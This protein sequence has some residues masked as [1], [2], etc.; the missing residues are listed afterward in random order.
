M[1]SRDESL[2]VSPDGSA[3]SSHS[4]DDNSAGQTSPGRSHGPASGRPRESSSSKTSAK[5]W[6]RRASRPV[7]LWLAAIIVLALAHPFVPNNR[8]MMVHFFTLGAL[9]NSIMVWSQ[10]FTEKFLH[11]RLP[12]SSR[13][14]QVALIYALNVGVILCVIGQAFNDAARGAQGWAWIVV[15]VGA[16]IV[17]VAVAIHAI[18]L[19]SQW[20][21]ARRGAAKS[22]SELGDYAAI[23]MFYIA[24]SLILPIGAGLGATL[25]HPLPG[26]WHDRL[27]VMHMAVNVLGFVG[28]TAAG[29]LTILFPAI[30]RA[31]VSS[32]RPIPTLAAMLAG[33]LVLSIGTISGR[34]ELVGIGM[35]VYGAGW[36]L[37]ARPWAGIV[38]NS[39]RV[40]H[41]PPAIFARSSVAFAVVWVI[42]TMLVAGISQILNPDE[43]ISTPTVPLVVGF[44][45]QLL[46]GVMCYLLPSTMGGGGKA[47][48]QGLATLDFMGPARTTMVNVGLIL[49]VLPVGGWLHIVGSFAAGI[50]LAMFVPLAAVSAKNQVKAIRAQAA[51]RRKKAD[52]PAI[53]EASST[54]SADA[55]GATTTDAAG[56]NT[57]TTDS[58]QKSARAVPPNPPH[59]RSPLAQV[60]A[61]MST[62]TLIACATLA[63]TGT[64]SGS[65]DNSDGSTVAATGHT[66]SVTVTAKGM[67]FSPNSIDVPA[68]DRL[69]VTLKNDGDQVHDLKLA[70][71]SETGK[72]DPGESKTFTS[73]VVTKKTK[74]WCTIPG[75]Q[76]RGMELTVNTKGGSSGSAGSTATDSDSDADTASDKDDVHA[77]GHSMASTNTDSPLKQEVIRDPSVGPAPE[78]TTHNIDLTVSQ[79]NR[80]IRED[81]TKRASWTFN[82]APM[83][84]VLRGHVGDE[85]VVHLKN[86]GSISHSI[87]FHAGMV[88]PD[89]PMRS[90]KPGES[91]EYRFRA[92]HAGIWLYH[93]G[94]API[95]MHIAA[96][97]FGAVII[98]PPDLAPV[99]HEY[100]MVQSELYGLGKDKDNPVDSALLRSEKPSKVVFNGLENQYVQKPLEL[101]HGERARFWLLNA[102][103]NISES[104]HIVG[105]QFDTSYKEG[106]Y[107]L[108]HGRDAFGVD[109][110]GSQALDLLAAQGGFVEAD[111]PEAGTYTMVNHQFADAERGAMGKIKVS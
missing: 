38:R 2:P 53:S 78:G 88:S 74:G 68:G 8:W 104:F 101:K 28:L 79:V 4:A 25:A 14:K 110:G 60:A 59:S 30:W 50:G 73:G 107:T 86:D 6:H 98:D 11:Q 23:V 49:W 90:I 39:R 46:I 82:G 93:C 96:G 65:S 62:I 76:M 77:S 72:V 61:T 22:G 34:F 70:D 42:G 75:H 15:T 17:G 67:S 108:R 57:G 7:S 52:E 36:I 83:G 99:D 94:T 35:V 55:A 10:H 47:V 97:M 41:E 111:F 45:A 103:P 44:G 69:K 37:C 43:I 26:T 85:F 51:A 5:S 29:T 54:S 81:G 3:R 91:L 95:S 12:D 18:S 92:E 20:V 9:M 31:R 33:I 13:P 32:F 56:A 109:D 80:T 27:I 89:Q 87:D 1:S 16:V 106:S 102:G 66:T 58:A 84:P 40:S 71:G 48:S 19:I 63:I 21:K 24:A 64:G 105:T 100:I